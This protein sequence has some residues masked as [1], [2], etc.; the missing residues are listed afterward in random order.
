MRSELVDASS[1]LDHYPRLMRKT[2]KRVAKRLV[3][4]SSPWKTALTM[5]VDAAILTLASALAVV[6]ANSSSDGLSSPVAALIPI[7]PAVTLPILLALGGYQAVVR[8]I[9]SDFAMRMALATILSLGVLDAMYAALGYFAIAWNVT[10]LYAVIGFCAVTLLRLVVRRFLQ[11]AHRNGRS[12]VLIYGAGDAGRQL[13]AALWQGSGFRPVAFADDRIELQGRTLS[14]LK[15]YSPKRLDEVRRKEPFDSILLAM[16]SITQKRRRQVLEQLAALSVKVMTLPK[17]DDLASGRKQIDELREVQIEDLLGRAAVTPD[18]SLL[19]RPIRNRC[20]M[21]TGAGGSIGSELSR[22]AVQR[23]AKRVV[24]FENSEYSLYTIERELTT[25]ANAGTTACEIVPVLGSVTDARL[26]RNTIKRHAVE[27]LYHAAAYKHV[28]L[29]ENNIASAIQNNVIGTR[30]TTETALECGVQDFVLVST[31]KAVRPTS[32]M[33]ASKRICELIVQALA[34]HHP[35]SRV[36]I[37]RFGNVLGSSGSVVPLF[38]RQIREGG[39]VTVTH[40]EVTRYFMT[41]SEAAQLVVQAGAMGRHG[42]VF[43]LDMGE[44]VLIRD[45]AAKMI[46]LAGL[47]VLSKENPQGDI[48]IAYTGLRPGEKLYEELLIGDNPEGTSHPRIC[49][50]RDAFIPLPQIKA[51]LDRMILAIVAD[52]LPRLMMEIRGLVAEFKPMLPG[53]PEPHDAAPILLKPQLK[54]QQKQK[55]LP[56]DLPLPGSPGLVH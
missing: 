45:L 44:P 36:A 20:V 46:Q 17:L 26:L 52:E 51:A 34:E 37:V 3:A 28:P 13:V 24:L 35:V 33:G 48:E 56:A 6:L 9:G 11:P 8:F 23:G 50:A 42:E 53:K 40:P 55:P 18:E 39:P 27:T 30:I 14:G 21:I 29:V 25:C 47:R 10:I 4:L 5:G 1:P 41:I 19:D 15:I 38:Q 49:H 54:P 31:D 2:H 12:A 16:P 7:A 43:V 22:L 32:V